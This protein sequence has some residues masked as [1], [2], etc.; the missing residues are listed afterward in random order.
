M[1]AAAGGTA[2]KLAVGKVIK[3]LKLQKS[4]GEIVPEPHVWE[5]VEHVISMIKAI[6]QLLIELSPEDKDNF[7]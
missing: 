3:L 1:N 5:S 4:K 6:K 2:R 7:T